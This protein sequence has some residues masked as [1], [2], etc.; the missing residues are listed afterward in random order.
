MTFGSSINRMPETLVKKFLEAFGQ[1]N[2]TVIAK[3]RVPE[4]WTV[5]KNVHI[6]SWL[7]QNDVLGHP[8]TRLFITHCGN[9]GQYEA[10]YHGVPML[11]F[12]LF[13]EQHVNAQRSFRKGKATYFFK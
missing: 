5:P 13:A 12:P 10:V 1:L 9:G 6:R 7:P 4:G 11:G 3:L 2:Q 8:N